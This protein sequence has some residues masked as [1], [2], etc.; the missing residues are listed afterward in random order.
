MLYDL[1]FCIL[2]IPWSLFTK[3][4]WKCLWHRIYKHQCKSPAIMNKCVWRNHLITALRFSASL[5][6]F[7]WRWIGNSNIYSACTVH[8]I[9]G[10]SEEGN[11]NWLLNC[12]QHKS[13]HVAPG[14]SL[15]RRQVEKAYS[16]K[17]W[18]H[19]WITSASNMFLML[20]GIKGWPV[21]RNVKLAPYFGDFSLIWLAWWSEPFIWSFKEVTN[22][23][24]NHLWLYL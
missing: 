9:G 21:K 4:N 18:G 22:V 10:N 23:L 12:S 24:G 1:T 16:N 6:G 2:I 14:E 7:F 19:K 5:C 3:N 20:F 8:E 15:E 11:R 13:V 17:L